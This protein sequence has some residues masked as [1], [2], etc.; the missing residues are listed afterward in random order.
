MSDKKETLQKEVD[1][2][3]KSYWKDHVET[4]GVI[5]LEKVKRELYDFKKLMEDAMKVYSHVTGGAVS[6][7]LV[8]AEEVIQR[9][10]ECKKKTDD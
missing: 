6:N 7:L 1:D 4:D 9:A 5:D 3:Y 8:T 2:L 10:D